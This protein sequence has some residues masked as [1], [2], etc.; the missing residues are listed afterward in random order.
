MSCIS[1]YGLF[2]DGGMMGGFEDV[3]YFSAGE[4]VDITDDLLG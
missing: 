4:W 3:V 1:E 2:I